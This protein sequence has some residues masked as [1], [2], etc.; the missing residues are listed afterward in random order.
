MVRARAV[1]GRGHV[2]QMADA[3][4]GQDHVAHGE[5]AHEVRR[6]ALGVG[7]RRGP[8]HP[9]VLDVAVERQR[10]QGRERARAV[11]HG[12]SVAGRP[13][14]GLRREDR[15]FEDGPRRQR[16]QALVGGRNAGWDGH[17][18]GRRAQRLPITARASRAGPLHGFADSFRCDHPMPARTARSMSATAAN[19][20]GWRMLS[21]GG[22]V[23]EPA[24]GQGHDAR[25]RRLSCGPSDR[26]TSRPAAVAMH[27]ALRPAA[28]RGPPARGRGSA[29][30]GTALPA[31]PRIRP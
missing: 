1:E 18:V 26:T 20:K 6:G 11:E 14:D 4:H 25:R 28:T 2:L 12:P 13:Q 10:L 17:Q 16:L 31:P 5:A 27:Q 24:V 23:E 21:K 15:H 30:R 22:I 29:A 7:V 19:V 3:A 8:L 9:M